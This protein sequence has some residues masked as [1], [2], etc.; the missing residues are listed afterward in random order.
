MSTPHDGRHWW[1]SNFHTSACDSPTLPLLQ[2]PT[3]CALFTSF[4]FVLLFVFFFHQFYLRSAICALFTNS[5][6]VPLF[7]HAFALVTVGR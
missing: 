2:T 5:I 4:I 6:S 1:D 7:V 3:T